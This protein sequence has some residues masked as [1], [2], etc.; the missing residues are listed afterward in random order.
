VTACP[1]NHLTSGKRTLRLRDEVA[2]IR[3]ADTGLML[4]ARRAGSQL[5]ASTAVRRTAAVVPSVSGS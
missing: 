3:I 4:A 1:R 2:Q 5:A